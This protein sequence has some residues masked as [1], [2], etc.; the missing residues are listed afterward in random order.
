MRH[1]MRKHGQTIGICL[2]VFVVVLVVGLLVWLMSDVRFR[3][4]RASSR[5]QIP[6]SRNHPALAQQGFHGPVHEEFGQR[7]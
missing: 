5:E 2:I 4:R 6:D 3:A 1:L 7:L